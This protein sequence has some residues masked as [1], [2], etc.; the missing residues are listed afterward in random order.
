[1]RGCYV[2]PSATGEMPLDAKKF[3]ERVFQPAFAHRA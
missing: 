3:D 2:F 1:M